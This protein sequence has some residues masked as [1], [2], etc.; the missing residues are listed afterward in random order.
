M[1]NIESMPVAK[2]DRDADEIA[3]YTI[4]KLAKRCTTNIKK[5]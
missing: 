3:A 1:S 5:L 4:Q 2:S